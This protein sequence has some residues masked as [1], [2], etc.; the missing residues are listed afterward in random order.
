MKRHLIFGCVLLLMSQSSNATTREKSINFIEINTVADQLETINET[1]QE[2]WDNAL[3]TF[4]FEILAGRK[5]TE[6]SITIIDE[7]ENQRHDTE[8]IYIQYSDLIRIKVLPKNV[9]SGSFEKLELMKTV[10]SFDLN[11]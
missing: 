10:N 9:I 4:Q 2:K 7:I 6:I 11:N 5:L 3:G 8:I 1:P